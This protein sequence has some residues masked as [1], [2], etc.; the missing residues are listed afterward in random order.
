MDPLR[1]DGVDMLLRNGRDRYQNPG[2]SRGLAG[3]LGNIVKGGFRS[4]FVG[5]FGPIFGGYAN[6]HRAP[7]A[8]V[9]P[10]T[11]GAL[12]S[13]TEASAAL[14][15]GIVVLTPALPMSASGTLVLTV[16]TATMSLL[17]ALVANGALVLTVNTAQLSS[18]VSVIANGTLTITGSAS[19][20]GLI[21]ILASGTLVLIP[22]NSDMSA[23]AFMEAAAGGP[24]PLSPEGLANAVWQKTI[25]GPI[26]GEEILRILAAVAAGKTTIDDLGGGAATV[27]FRN[28]TDALDRV[29]A[30]MQ[31]SERIDVTL[32]LD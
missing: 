12:S 16:Q 17:A 22:D 32:E 13:Y 23:L 26:T 4:R 21:P 15:Q 31:D 30:D 24:T 28:L 8:F 19:L 14:T 7:S 1:Q 11:P 27:V 3:D 25:D 2:F 5:G 18:A 6:G 9:L 10:T 20:G 29:T